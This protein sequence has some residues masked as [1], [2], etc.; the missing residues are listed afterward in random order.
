MRRRLLAAAAAALAAL[1][2]AALAAAGW[3]VTTFTLENGLTGVVIEDRRAPV[4]THMVFD[5]AGGAD[6]PP[7][8]SGV[9]HYLE[10][11]MF[12]D[13]D[14]EARGGFS[15]AVAAEGGRDNAFTT[16]DYTAYFQRVAADRLDF[17]MELEAARMASLE[18]DP[19]AALTE[20]DVILE[21]RNQ[22]V[23]NSPGARLSERRDAA[24][25]LNH[26]YGN[27]LIGW[28]HEIETLTLDDALAFHDRF[29]APANAI[30]VVAGDV[31]PEAVR[32]LAE[33]HYGPIPAREAPERARPTEPPHL[34]ARRVTYAD[35]RVRQPY[36]A[37]THLA[38][39][40]RDGRERAAALTMLSAV[41]G[42]G[43]ASHLQRRLV[44]ER[45]L[46]VSAGAWYAGSGRDH[47]R[48]TVYAAPRPGV[49]LDEMEAAL[50]AELDAFLAGPG[51]SEE[52][53]A[54]RKTAWRA[55]FVY[56][57]DSQSGLARRYGAGLATDLTLAQIEAWPDALDAVAAEDVMAAARAVLD[58]DTA[59][60]SRLER[61]APTE[62]GEG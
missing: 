6:E 24:L 48:F 1:P 39:V 53:L 19:E 33:A 34:S 46:A 38:P 23:E 2:G 44:V 51:P 13:A 43:V 20:R 42:D 29:Y 21:E 45:G 60:T 11:L 31:S 47:G 16:P 12:K 59:V 52:E 3:P 10:H 15:A 49:S 61:A 37:R 28:R 62:G 50:D 58:P 36:V 30:L 26:P 56:G 57:Q 32:E 22:R 7:G 18:V 27:P 35:P 40:R 14:A 55:S 8:R 41:L 25:F 17:V 54:R 9:A 5:A 4:V